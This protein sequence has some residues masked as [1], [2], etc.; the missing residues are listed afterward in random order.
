MH[1][2]LAACLLTAASAV[3][4]TIPEPGIPQSCG[5]QLKGGNA[6]PETLAELQALGVRW[7]R[8]GFIWEAVEKEKGVYDFSAY[9]TLLDTARERGLGVIGVIAFNNKLYGKV[10]EPAG[11][12]G[13]AA[14]AA[15]LA[16]R[17]KDRSILWE[18]WNEPNVR[19]FWGAQ[20]QHPKAKANTPEFADEYTA[21]VKATVPAMRAADPACIVMA[22]S[23]SC[24]GWDA[25]DPWMER[26][27]ADG[28][29]DSGISAWSVHPYSLKR[30]EDYG[31]AYVRLRGMLARHQ[32]PA[33]FPIINSERGYPIGK[34]EGWAGGV[35]DMKEYQAWHL[36]RQQ[37]NDLM[38]GIRLTSWYEWSGKEGFSVVD[39]ETKSPAY[40]ACQ[41]MLRQ[42]DGCTFDRRLDPADGEDYVLRFVRADGGERLVAW[43]APPPGGTPDKAVAHDLAVPVAGAGPLAGVALHGEAA[44]LPVVDGKV[45]LHLTGAPQ[46]VTVR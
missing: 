10:T 43:T 37:L 16:A 39:G 4:A 46:Y 12:A 13:Y 3:A 20:T 33:G 44:S 24:M 9:D 34:A 2:P 22:G 28:I 42:L 45:T 18:V 21:L 8:R 1:L 25:V 41:V 7:F 14:F 23:V 17:Y 29:L 19:T 38:S 5:M 40:D 15:A 27:F 6:T 32:V 35:G 30:P 26:C 11:A 31:A 36:V